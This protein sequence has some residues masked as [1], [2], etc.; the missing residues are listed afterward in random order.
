MMLLDGDLAAILLACAEGRLAEVEGQIVWRYAVALCVVMA[1]HGY[2][3]SY[4]KNTAIKGLDR[5]AKHENVQVFHAGT[6]KDDKGHVIATGGRVL[7]VTALAKTVQEA[8]AL[9]YKAVD[10]ID[11]KEGFC[12]RDIGWRAI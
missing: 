5:A 6:A 3:G 4:V 11:W 7:G 10:E 2:P 12:R 9:A 1:A 8:Q